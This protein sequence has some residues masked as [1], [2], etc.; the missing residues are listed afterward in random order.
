M[1]RHSS[2]EAGSYTRS[3]VAW[4][5]PWT[6]VAAGV[7]VAL[8]VAISA[9]G[10][11]DVPSGGQGLGAARATTSSSPTPTPTPTESPSATPPSPSPSPSP[12]PRPKPRPKPTPKPKL[13]TKGITVQVLDA[14]GSG[15]AGQSMAARLG[16]LGFAIV[17]VNPGLSDTGHT[18]VFWSAD[19]YRTA[20]KALA[21]H[22]GWRSGPKP[23]DL[24]PTVALHVVVTD[25][26][27]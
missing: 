4:F 10:R 12:K 14:T 3:V 25:D 11:S 5:L 20:A 8:W 27:G 7:L 21:A 6:I 23:A 22:F 2:A 24:S 17:A 9:L 26:A 15:T 16:K 1:G 13:I 18:T 19:Q